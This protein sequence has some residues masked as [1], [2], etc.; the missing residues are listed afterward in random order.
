MIKQ[1][2]SIL[3]TTI[4]AVLISGCVHRVDLPETTLVT[5]LDKKSLE[6]RSTADQ[7][8]INELKAFLSN[9]C[10]WRRKHPFTPNLSFHEIVF[11]SGDKPV[12]TFNNDYKYLWFEKY[13]CHMSDNQ[14]HK[15][16]RIIKKMRVMPNMILDELK[17]DE[18]NQNIEPMLKTPV[19]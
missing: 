10:K 13:G 7:E 17:I 12:V 2:Q 18:S 6:S 11:W 4:I 9:E 5:S 15:L 14:Y 16:Y 19:Y 1:I 8:I 3:S